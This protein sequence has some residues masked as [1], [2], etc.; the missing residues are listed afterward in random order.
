MPRIVPVQAKDL[1]LS[2]PE[3][4]TDAVIGYSVSLPD[5]HASFFPTRKDAEEYIAWYLRVKDQARGDSNPFP[6]GEG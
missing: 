6:D 3:D 4:P 5:G 2:L 1:G